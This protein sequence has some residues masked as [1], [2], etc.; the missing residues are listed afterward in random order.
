MMGEKEPL[1]E[2]RATCFGGGKIPVGKER[3]PHARE[4]FSIEA[5]SPQ[6]KRYCRRG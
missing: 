6:K 5:V 2:E 1:Y 3:K 4:E